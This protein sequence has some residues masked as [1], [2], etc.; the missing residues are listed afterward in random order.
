MSNTKQRG[1]Y[2][3]EGGPADNPPVR[4]LPNV[5]AGRGVGTPHA[6]GKGIGPHKN[7]AVG[8]VKR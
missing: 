4:R 7:P 5:G 6:K 8:N 1:V 3:R 2:R